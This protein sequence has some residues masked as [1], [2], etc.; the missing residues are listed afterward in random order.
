[1]EHAILAEAHGCALVDRSYERARQGRLGRVNLHVA[2]Y[3]LGA[4]S[5]GL[6]G[7]SLGL[8]GGGGSILAVPCMVYLVGVSNPHVA[9]GTSAVAVVANAAVGLFEHAR[10]KTVCWR[11][12]ATFSLAGVLS[13][14][15]GSVV[16][17]AL[18]GQKL[19]VCFALLMIVVGALMFR[20]RDGE[21]DPDVDLS[22]Q[23]APKLVGAGALTGALSGF[24]GIDRKSTRLNSSHSGES[25]MPSSA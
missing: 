7:L 25:R 11:C 10:H 22:R 2:Q 15:G 17:K 23:N 5:G 12:A 14:V 19:L 20:S 16:S 9:I 4:C 1:M 24:F 8:F 18:N 6:V 3:L 21:G 13:A